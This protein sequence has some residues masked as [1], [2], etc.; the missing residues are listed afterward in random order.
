MLLKVEANQNTAFDKRIVSKQKHKRA[1]PFGWTW[2][3]KVKKYSKTRKFLEFLKL[4]AKP[5]VLENVKR[6]WKKSWIV[7]EIE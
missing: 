1:K 4:K 3:F 2:A 5:K 6:S 7:V